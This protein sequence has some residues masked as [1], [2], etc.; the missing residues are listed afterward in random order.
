M[1]GKRGHEEEVQKVF[2]GDYVTI[3]AWYLFIH[4]KEILDRVMMLQIAVDK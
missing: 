2:F 3:A 4:V 1:E